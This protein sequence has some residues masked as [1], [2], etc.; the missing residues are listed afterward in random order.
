MKKRIGKQLA[1]FA[2]VL[3]LAL[4]ASGCSNQGQKPEETPVVTTTDPESTTES[5]SGEVLES[6]SEESKAAGSLT[7]MAGR[8]ITEVKEAKKLCALSP[9]GAIMVYAL[10]PDRLLG[11]NYQ[12]NDLEK[13]QIL[14]EYSDLPV[15]GMG[16]NLNKEA[17]IELAPDYCIMVV[18]KMGENVVAD[19]DQ[20][21]DDLG[22]PVVVV[23]GSLK[24]SPEAF[25]LLGELTGETE[26]AMNLSAYARETLDLADSVEIPTEEQ[27]TVYFGNGPESLETAPKGSVSS[28]VIDL[29]GGVNV[30]E[31]ELGQG[32]RVEV[33]LEQVLAWNPQV[34]LL[35]GEPKQGVSGSQAVEA[36][37]QNESFATVDAVVE[38][39]VYGSP[40]APFSWIDRP[41]SINRLIGIKWLGNLLYPQYYDYDIDEEVRS[42]Y[43]L[44]Y[45]KDLSSE[46]IAAL[47]LD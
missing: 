4:A 31:L 29:V 42:F 36:L 13:S 46:E 7:D 8:P 45:H 32:S 5:M 30:A 20:M 38:G 2:A 34:I 37:K 33:S 27:I 10:A 25:E 24:D 12:L 40:K 1:G 39:R 23:S 21:E 9:D 11:W 18:R 26:Q 16:D 22:I 3:L 44:F 47:Y 14:P 19:A 6:S 15:V 17:I 28:E 43:Q 35:N 41:T